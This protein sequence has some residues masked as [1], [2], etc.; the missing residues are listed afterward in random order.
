M[1]TVLIAIGGLLLGLLV[2]YALFGRAPLPP[3]PPTTTTTTLPSPMAGKKFD[4]ETIRVLVEKDP[5]DATRCRAAFRDS[6][7]KGATGVIVPKDKDGV[8]WRVKNKDCSA[9]RLT[10]T[11]KSVSGKLPLPGQ[12]VHSLQIPDFLEEKETVRLAC[13]IPKARTKDAS[14][15]NDEDEEL[16]DPDKYHN[17]KYVYLLQICKADGTGCREA[18]PELD[19]RRK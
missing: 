8:L 15:P 1:K 12:C 7:Q 2:G 10:I 9:G 4:F 18:D 6:A 11:P 13:A 19:F 17:K 14:D 16:K 5:T 3:P